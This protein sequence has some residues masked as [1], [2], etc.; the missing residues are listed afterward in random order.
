MGVIPRQVE[1]GTGY[2]VVLV[3]ILTIQII[4]LRFGTEK[5]KK[6]IKEAEDAE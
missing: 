2:N 3:A 5:L 6:A 1:A 4:G